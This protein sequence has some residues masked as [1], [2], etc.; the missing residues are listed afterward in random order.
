MYA[1]HDIRRPICDGEFLSI[2]STFYKFT[3]YPN[4][5]LREQKNRHRIS[6]IGCRKSESDTCEQPNIIEKK[7]KSRCRKSAVGCRK[8]HTCVHTLIQ[9]RLFEIA[10]KVITLVINLSFNVQPFLMVDGR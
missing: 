2:F 4:F 9:R 5:A 8:P 1:A 10:L 7:G 3:C 6:C